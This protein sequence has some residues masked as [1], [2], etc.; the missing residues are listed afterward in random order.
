[1]FKIEKRKI[2][3]II[4]LFALFEPPYINELNPPLHS[5]CIAIKIIGLFIA[6]FSFLVKSGK[7]KR[8]NN[9]V[10]VLYV[11]YCL[12]RLINTIIQGQEIN[13]AISDFSFCM[14]FIYACMDEKTKIFDFLSEVYLILTGFVIVNLITMII[15][16]S[17]MWSVQ[18]IGEYWFLGMDNMF[19]N[20]MYPLT[21]ISVL[22][23]KYRFRLI[24]LVT[25]GISVV[26]LVSRWAATSMVGIIIFLILSFMP[27]KFS[28]KIK[29]LYIFIS[30]IIISIMLI[31]SYSSSLI[32]YIVVNVLN[33][34]MTFSNRSF[35]WAKALIYIIQKPWFGYGKLTSDNFSRMLRYGS[36]PHNMWLYLLF[37][38]GVIGAVVY[39]II[40][41]QA[42]RKIK[43]KIPEK[44]AVVL[45]AALSGIYIMGI[46]ESLAKIF[47]E[48]PLILVITF[49]DYK[50]RE[51]Q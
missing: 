30:S 9:F 28:R 15:Y 21:I 22:L 40:S 34:D 11:A 51:E 27:K 6:M 43:R 50:W 26:T 3:S 23:L 41:C 37:T 2:I 39:I 24:Y 31:N 32:S 25:I 29:P 13:A 47:L 4:I 20:Y 5:M 46:T 38:A 45:S 8:V 48:I 18:A 7:N 1:M 14:Y 44:Y 12:Y 10:L 19:I 16:P 36:H 42:F 17:G 49:K 35:I 33:K